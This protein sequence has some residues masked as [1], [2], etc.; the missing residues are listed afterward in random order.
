M[1]SIGVNVVSWNINGCSTPI[2][3]K[4]ILNYLKSHGTDVAY[5]QESHFENE[6]EALKLKRDWVGKI[7]HN[8]VSS[9]SRGVMILIHKKLHFVL[10]QQ[11]KDDDGR[12]LCLQALINGVKVVLCNVYAPNKDEP[13]FIYKINEMLGNIEGH[14]LLG[15]DFNNVLDE[16]IDRSTINTALV[17]K[18]GLALKSL[19]EDIGLEDIW[20]L[21]H[22]LEKEYTFYTH[23]HKTYSRIDYF[24]IS[25]ACVDLVVNSKIGVIALTDHAPV[26]L[27]INLQAVR[28]SRGRWRLNTSVLQDEQFVLSLQNDIEYFSQVNVGSTDRLATVW[29][30]LKAFV[31]GKCLG[32]CSK[33]IKE[34]KNKIKTLEEKIGIFE[35]QLAEKFDETKFKEICKL[36]FNLHEI[37]NRKAE[38]ALFRLKTNFYENGEKTGKLL[39]RQLK[40]IDSQNVI[41]AIKKDDKLVT[42]SSEINTVFETFLPK[43]LYI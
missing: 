25:N 29:D 7:F 9:K 30:A 6:N 16:Y 23:S 18:T 33:K 28:V 37:Y 10:L 36:K 13:K 14:V 26:E 20:R 40:K 32:Y 3:R 34:N 5:I 12:L 15:G 22:P 17:T 31:R 39:A 19:R 43:P 11:F 4:K 41:T 1:S 42:S 27:R 24:L 2:K 21:V 8:S 35:K 38:Y